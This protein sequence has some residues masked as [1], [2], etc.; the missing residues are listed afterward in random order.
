M[1]RFVGHNNMF[2][3]NPNTRLME[4]S[5]LLQSLDAFYS[6]PIKSIIDNQEFLHH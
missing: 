1:S 5:E 4:C 6:R 2:S 3:L